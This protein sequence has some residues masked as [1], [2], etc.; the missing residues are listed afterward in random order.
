M[1]ARTPW[2]FSGDTEELSDAGPGADETASAPES[3][4]DA[5][6]SDAAGAR[7]WAG[8]VSGAQRVVDWATERVLAPHAEHED[9]RDHP[10]CVICR[11][12]SV[13]GDVGLRAPSPAD[14][15]DSADAASE[16]PAEQLPGQGPTGG[17]PRPADRPGVRWIPIRGESTGS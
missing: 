6:E 5:T 11:T 3:E 16:Q 7:D 8:L 13:L 12:M 10:D 17:A 1:T 4:A 14:Q 15:A 2:W 9:P